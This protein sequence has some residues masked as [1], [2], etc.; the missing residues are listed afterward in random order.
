MTDAASAM[1]KKESAF[2][3]GQKVDYK[4]KTNCAG[5]KNDSN[6]VEA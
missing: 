5:A 2:K 4:P 3:K 6:W 1:D